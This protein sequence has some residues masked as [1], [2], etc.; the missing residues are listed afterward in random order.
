MQSIDTRIA[1]LLP[2]ARRLL[3]EGIDPGRLEFFDSLPDEPMHMPKISDRDLESQLVGWS[4]ARAEQTY[5]VGIAV[6]LLLNS[7][8]FLKNGRI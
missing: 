8:T 4:T 3:T 7:A 2:V 1:R 5:L 6:G